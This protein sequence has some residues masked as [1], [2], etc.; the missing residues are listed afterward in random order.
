MSRAVPFE[1]LTL[2][3]RRLSGSIWI[4]RCGLWPVSTSEFRITADDGGSGWA[5]SCRTNGS[6]YRCAPLMH[7]TVQRGIHEK[8]CFLF[9][10]LMTVELLHHLDLSSDC[11][12]D[13]GGPGGTYLECSETLKIDV[14]EWSRVPR[15]PTSYD[16]DDDEITLKLRLLTGFMP[17]PAQQML[18]FD[19]CEKERCFCQACQLSSRNTYRTDHS[20][21]KS[22]QKLKQYA[23]PL[24]LFE[25]PDEGRQYTKVDD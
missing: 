19:W 4:C 5:R 13:E 20:C 21:K 7:C 11:R 1:C 2:L 6:D 25:Q 14:V 23:V 15:L 22:W 24:F 10:V 18:K 9:S 3:R 17:S 12:V 8:S 16:R